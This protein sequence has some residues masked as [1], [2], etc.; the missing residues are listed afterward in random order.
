MMRRLKEP[1][2]PRLVRARRPHGMR[3]RPPSRRSRRP[4]RLRR[5]RHLRCKASMRRSNPFTN[6]GSE[7]PTGFC[8]FATQCIR[9]RGVLSSRRRGFYR[10]AILVAV[11]DA[12]ASH[13]LH[14]LAEAA[15]GAAQGGRT[16]HEGFDNPAMASRSYARQLL[17]TRE[18]D[19]ERLSSARRR[20]ALVLH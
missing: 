3:P 4:R 20:Q 9:R 11:C 2:S 13:V 5:V 12:R 17:R 7:V 8:G 15:G 1:N 6:P 18:A 19:G 10:E 14:R 16:S